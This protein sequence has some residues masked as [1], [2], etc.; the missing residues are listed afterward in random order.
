VIQYQYYCKI[1]LGTPPQKA[2]VILDTGSHH[3]WVPARNCTNCPVT[4]RKFDPTR[5]S[6][7][8]VLPQREEIKYGKGEIKGYYIED[9]LAFEHSALPYRLIL[10]DYQKDTEHSQ[11]DGIMG[12]SNSKNYANV[13]DI[14]QKEGQIASSSFAFELGL[15]ELR[16]KSYF[17]YNLSAE[18]FP[19]AA[20]IRA[21]RKDYWTIPVREIRVDGR[22][23]TIKD[24]LVDSGTSLIL[25]PQ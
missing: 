22:N 11:A 25:M 15:K 21:S 12:L 19:E 7:A 5:S 9:R 1:A 23:F 8:T 18:D 3:L 2:E 16:Q 10:A 6:T 20:Y 24:A 13:F 17:Y 4:V 14:L